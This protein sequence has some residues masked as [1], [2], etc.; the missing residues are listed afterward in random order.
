MVSTYRV[1]GLR[2]GISAKWRVDTVFSKN[3]VFYLHIFNSLA[4]F[5]VLFYVLAAQL[6]KESVFF[7]P[8][9][10]ANRYIYRR[11]NNFRMRKFSINVFCYPL[12]LFF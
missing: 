3:E 1:H 12:R 5:R 11:M 7:I 8:V 9:A 2:L 10:V 4:F 6:L